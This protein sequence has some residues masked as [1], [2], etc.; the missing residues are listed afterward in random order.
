MPFHFS[1]RRER[2]TANDRALKVPLV[3][4]RSFDLIKA[5]LFRRQ[6]NHF[7]PGTYLHEVP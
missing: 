1:I 4:Y 5:E 2:R 7:S 3:K 6:G